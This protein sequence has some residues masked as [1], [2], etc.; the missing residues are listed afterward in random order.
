MSNEWGKADELLNRVYPNWPHIQ[1]HGI[2]RGEVASVFRE[3]DTLQAELAA[4]QDAEARAH[5]VCKR[6]MGAFVDAGDVAVTVPDD[7]DNLVAG[8]NQL[9]TQRDTLQAELARCTL[10]LQQIIDLLDGP[11]GDE[12]FIK[13]QIIAI[14]QATLDATKGA[15]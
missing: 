6:V 9:I 2:L 7:G 13:G 4:L 1:N 15:G 14:A 11:R 3:R 8:I 10:T 12:P 5:V